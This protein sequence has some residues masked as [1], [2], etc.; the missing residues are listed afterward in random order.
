MILIL[1]FVLAVF[2]IAWNWESVT[3]RGEVVE[4]MSGSRLVSIRN[5]RAYGF[6]L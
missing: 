1:K 2:L 3:G 4:V 6:I 5:G